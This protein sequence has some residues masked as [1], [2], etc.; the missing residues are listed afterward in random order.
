EQLANQFG[1]ERRRVRINK[2]RGVSFRGGYHDFAIRR[3]GLD[4]FP[5]LVANEHQ[6]EFSEADLASGN[7]ALDALLGG[8]L[9]VGTSTLLLGPAGTGKSTIATQFA[10]AA[11][12]RGQRAALYVFDEN[13]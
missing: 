13:I 8:G 6:G 7:T 10:V 5:R 9:P 4:V 3:G 11:A 2:M 1:A 12:A